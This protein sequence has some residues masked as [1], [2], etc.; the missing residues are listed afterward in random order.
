LLYSFVNVY[1]FFSAE[2]SMSNQPILF[3]SSRCSHSKQVIDTLNGLN[4][5]SLFQMYPIDGKTRDQLPVFLKSIPT[6]Y[7]PETKDVYAGI[8]AIFSYIS[9]PVSSR[10]EIPTNA[11]TA[12]PVTQGATPAATASTSDYQAWSFSG[13][14]SLTEGYSSWDKP[15]NF[16]VDDQLQYTYLGG[17]KA[18]PA[19]SEPQTKQSYDGDKAGRNDDIKNRLEQLQKQRDAEFKG[20]AR[21]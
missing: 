11:P 2:T 10:R 5:T 16:S 18:T 7:V 6:V 8:Q 9:K 13:S 15:G 4:K 3:Y 14:G 12:A 17:T 1:P 19:P 20:I 21:Q